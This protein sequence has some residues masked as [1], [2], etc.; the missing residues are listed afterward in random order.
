MSH[1]DRS[2]TVIEGHEDRSVTVTGGHKDMSVTV[3]GVARG[4]LSHCHREVV[5]K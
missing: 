5:G 3:T 4:Q 2:V 1:E